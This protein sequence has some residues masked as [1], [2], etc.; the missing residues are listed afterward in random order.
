MSYILVQNNKPTMKNINNSTD[1]PLFHPEF[2]ENITNR[3]T[4][5]AVVKT[6]S[7]TPAYPI[8]IGASVVVNI[9]L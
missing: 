7:P 4:Y 5:K 1:K 8:S 6:M 3:P 2:C 9:G